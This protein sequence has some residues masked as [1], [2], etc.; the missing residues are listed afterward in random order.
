MF[1]GAAVRA[2]IVTEPTSLSVSA[3]K[4][5][6]VWYTTLKDDGDFLRLLGRG[7]EDSQLVLMLALLPNIEAFRIDGLSPFPLLDW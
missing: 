6:V 4:A 2:G 5:S 3:L 1:V 7:V